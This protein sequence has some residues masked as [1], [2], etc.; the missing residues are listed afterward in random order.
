MRAPVIAV[1]I[2]LMGVAA[3]GLR[4]QQQFSFFASFTDAAFGQP[5]TT[6]AQD[7]LEVRENNVAGRIVRME[8]INWPVKVE[9]LLDNG[10]GIG[11]NNLIHLRNGVRAFMEALPSDVEVAFVTTA[12]QPRNVI[13][14][15]ADRQALLR[16]PDLLTLDTAAGRFVDALIEVAARIDKARADRQQGNF[17]PVVVVLGSTAAEGSMFGQRDVEQLLQRFQQR[18]ATV[19]VIMLSSGASGPG[20][21]GWVQAE[22]GQAVTRLTGGRY[23]NIAAPSRIATLLPEIGQQIAK[24]HAKQ[25]QQ[26]RIT[27]ERPLGASGQIGQLTM[28]GPSNVVVQLSLDG[29]LPK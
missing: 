29:H 8:P 25:S 24:S 12:P 11:V 19:H 9:L 20:T 5:V 18:G 7:Q 15:T 23:D 16:A 27:L 28:A 14:P 22:L 26:F 17:F 3:A 21:G 10:I 1:F 4:A 13:R 2:A 6:V